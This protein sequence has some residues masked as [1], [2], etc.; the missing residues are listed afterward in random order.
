ML[1]S[2][3]CSDPY[4]SRVAHKD[5]YEKAK[6]LHRDVSPGNILI[7]HGKDGT[8]R[9]LLIDWQFAK[10]VDADHKPRLHWRVVSVFYSVAYRYLLTAS[11]GTWQFYS[12]GLHRN[13]NKRTHDLRDDLESFLWVALYM[14]GVLR[15]MIIPLLC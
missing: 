13:P 15:P 7:V 14:V 11:Q 6:L 1:S 4:A 2:F 5:A 3:A 12:Y 8:A 10:K 9:G